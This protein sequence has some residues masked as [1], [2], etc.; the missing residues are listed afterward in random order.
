[1]EKKLLYVDMDGVIADFWKAILELHPEI[2]SKHQPGEDIEQ[3]VDTLC[4][5]NVDIFHNLDTIEGGIEAVKLLSQLYDVYFLSTPMWNVPESFSGKRIWL[6]RHFGGW[7]KK[8]LILTHRKDLN[9]GDYLIDDR[10]KNGVENFKGEHIH[11]GTEE[12]PTWASVVDYLMEKAMQEIGEDV[13]KK[14]FYSED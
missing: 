5:S 4:E 1:M 13:S 8:R 6:E 9:I 2:E 11:F 14:G 12:F 10:K 3:V 7:C